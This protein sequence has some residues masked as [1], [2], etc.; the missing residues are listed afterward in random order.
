M[1]FLLKNIWLY[2]SNEHSYLRGTIMFNLLF[3]FLLGACTSNEKE[4]ETAAVEETA[5]TASPIHWEECSYRIGEHIC[6]F[7]LSA[8]T[9]K[10]WSLYENYGR[11]MIIDLSA[12]WCSVCKNS[13]PFAEQFVQNWAEYDLMWITILLENDQG[14]EPTAQDLVEWQNNY[15]SQD[16]I[17]LAGSRDLIDLSAENGFP[18]TSWPTFVILTDDLIIFHGVGGWSEDYLNQRLTEMLVLQ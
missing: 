3:A 4:I 11:P 8:N 9:G 18:L 5:E 15:G 10:M 2:L 17:I 16:S 14:E 13:A 7:E 1:E 12:E 6:N